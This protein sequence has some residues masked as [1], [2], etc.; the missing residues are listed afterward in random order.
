MVRISSSIAVLALIV[1]IAFTGCGGSDS[2]D[3]SSSDL[4]NFASPGSLVF[5]EGQLKPS[6][7]TAAN[8]D[9][10][11]HG[12]A[13]VDNL[14]DFVVSKLESSARKDGESLDFAKEVEPWLGQRASVAFER[15]DGSELSEPL[16]AI[17]TTDPKATEAFVSKRSKE[18]GGTSKDVSYEG[19]DFE[20][21]GPQGNAIGVFDEALVIASSES[22]FKA[23]V[24]A[25]TGDSL[26]DEDRFQNAISAAS[27]GSFADVYVDVGAI[28]K[29]S[30]DRVD[31][32]AQE[33]LQSAGI[34]P[35]EATAVASLV[36]QS[37]H[38]EIDLSSDL[39]GEKAPTGD[40][41]KLLGS[42]PTDSFAAVGTSG[43]GGQLEEAVDSLDEAGIPPELP[44]NKLKDT[45]G[46]AGIDLDKIAGSFEEGAVFAEGSS[47]G[48][49][50]G[51]LVL[52]TDGS[53]EAA[54]AIAS[55][56]TLLRS[57]RVPGVTA[58][59]GKASGFSIRSP[60]L[61]GKPLVVLA[62]DD[63]IVVG[64]GTRAAF[65]GLDTESSAAL[66]SDPA[67][68][69]A[70]SLLGETPIV[71]YVNGPAARHLAEVLVPRSSTDFWE[72]VPYLKFTYIGIGSSTEG[73]LAT[74][75]IVAG[76][77]T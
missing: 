74:A 60:E 63:R 36:P 77:G 52:R 14:G 5:V 17:E 70:V 32:Q 54:S 38:I 58:V 28:I 27:E 19:V 37:D 45:L 57:A 59:S 12:L 46:Q 2:S 42:L 33:V 44:P 35:S 68:Q 13:G 11:A 15:L 10:A 51:A 31:P 25:A 66:A 73:D 20:V 75:K 48:S 69:A 9:W 62:K 6:G 23:A 8:I 76:I 64:Y 71:G 56:G 72:I 24:D 47:R 49:L 16:I 1:A 65:A 4:A 30:D 39:G 3:S 21:G 61:G 22:E 34:D 55:L 41:S 7:A 18:G 26:A 50:G 67:Y 53:N 43:F 40:V 29:Q